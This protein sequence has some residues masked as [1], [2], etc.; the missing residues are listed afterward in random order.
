M[1]HTFWGRVPGATL[2]WQERA[3]CIKQVIDDDFVDRIFLSNDSVR[4]DVEREKS[5]PGWY[6]VYDSQED[7]LSETN[8]RIATEIQRI[9][10]ENPKRFFS[11]CEAVGHSSVKAG[12]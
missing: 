4:G 12:R 8:R 10:V 7:S 9:T 11:R 3:G 5:Q 6:A 2:P 1:D